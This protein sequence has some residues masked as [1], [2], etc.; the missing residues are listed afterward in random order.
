MNFEYK[1]NNI[2]IKNNIGFNLKDTLECGQCF[3]F[4]VVSDYEYL[5]VA[6]G[7]LLRINSSNDTITLFDT[8]LEDFKNIWI[9]YFDFSRNY[10]DIKEALKTKDPFLK[11]AVEYAPGIKILNQ[12]FFECL[13]SFII[14]QNNRIPMIKKVISNLSEAYSVPVGSFNGKTYYSFPDAQTL[15]NAG[16]D[17]LMKCKTGFRAKYILDACEKFISGEISYEKISKMDTETARNL[18]MTIKGV[19]PK[20]SDCVL[21]FSL[22]RHEVFPTDVWVKRVMS[23][24]Y[25]NGTSAGIKAIHSFADENFGSLSGFAQQ[26]LFYYARTLKIGSKK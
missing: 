15:F 22:G 5:I 25:F 20:V 6:H 13:I 1:N 10:E 19:G 23:E 26:Y 18:L 14:S 8:S 4:E 16:E 24:L 12:E 7:K 9:N 21:L 11:T 3:R 17:G 2:I